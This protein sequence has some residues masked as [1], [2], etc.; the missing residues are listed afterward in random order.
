MAYVFQNLEGYRWYP[1]T[2]LMIPSEVPFAFHF[3]M[4][5]LF[6]FHIGEETVIHN[7]PDIGVSVA[8]LREVIRNKPV[9]AWWAP[10]TPEQGITAVMRMRSLIGSRYDLLEGNCEHPVVWAV[11]GRWRSEQVQA[12]RAGV[13]LASA[14]ALAAAL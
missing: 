7:M 3:M 13:V 14:F 2:A 5:D 8:R 10:P 12:A 9:K 1:G 11:T 6:N 4:V